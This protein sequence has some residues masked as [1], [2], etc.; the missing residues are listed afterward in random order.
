L[1]PKGCK[2]KKR[3]KKKKKKKRKKEGE[4]K[5]K[6]KGLP[7]GMTFYIHYCFFP[8]VLGFAM[9]FVQ[10]PCGCTQIG[11]MG[12]FAHRQG[13]SGVCFSAAAMVVRG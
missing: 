11:V 3:E 4:K 13:R 9:H 1:S 2:K 5:E 6:K 10:R 7:A 8:R 12:I